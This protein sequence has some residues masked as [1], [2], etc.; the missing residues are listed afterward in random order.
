MPTEAQNRKLQYRRC[1]IVSNKKGTPLQTLLAQAL[2][3]F[4]HP[5]ERQESLS[6]RGMER[7][8]INYAAQYRGMLCGNMVIYSQGAEQ[9]LLRAKEIRQPGD[10]AASYPLEVLSAPDSDGTRREFLESI[11]Y[12]CICGDHL[13]ALQSRSLR[14][15][16]FEQY[17]D[18]ILRKGGLLADEHRLFLADQASS[19]ATAAI[20]RSHVKSV[21]LGV[22]LLAAEADQTEERRARV[23][24]G[25]PVVRAL[26]ELIGPK[27][28]HM[29]LEDAIDGNI[30]A[31]IE[32]RW[33]RKTTEGAQD[34]LDSLAVAMRNLDPEDVNIRLNDGTSLRGNDLKLT[35]PVEV[36]IRNG[37]V[38]QASLFRVMRE[39]MADM[40]ENGVIK[41]A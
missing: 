33:I 7:R 34:V 10:A 13:L 39:A 30:E 8:F 4:E 20:T 12:F 27:M 3:K 24:V 37:I 32:L 15:S 1:Q 22:P 11:F 5:S 28:D 14:L 38:E 16:A 25:G 41:A 36:K 31:N 2:K 9:L 35:V 21:S 40:L 19:A 23:K 29:R 17:L 6:E 18:W 26:R